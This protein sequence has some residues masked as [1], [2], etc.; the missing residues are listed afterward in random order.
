MFR[1]DQLEEY[2]P[3]LRLIP[4]FHSLFIIEPCLA[5]S[6][7]YQS[8][9]K[10]TPSEFD[11]VYQIIQ[12]MLQEY[13]SDHPGRKT[14]L[15]SSFQMLVT[16]LSRYYKP[17]D[18]PQKPLFSFGIAQSVSWMEEHFKENCTV[19]ELADISKMSVRHF[20][21]LFTEIYHIS[22]KQYILQQRL[23]Y[24]CSLLENK[25][26][27]CSITQIALDAGFS[28][29]NYFSRQFHHSYGMTPSEYRCRKEV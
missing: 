20:T 17:S 1:M 2:L 27:A 10:L 28:S 26:K 16:C 24:A 11:S 25:K 14:M 23:S 18:A 13:Y 5:G 15:L 4:G 7:E 22:P 29:S 12:L 8:H 21:R 6:R 19:Q 9:L 3:D